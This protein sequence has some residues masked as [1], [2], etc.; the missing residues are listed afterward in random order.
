LRTANATLLAER[1]ALQAQLD[2]YKPQMV[3]DA[4]RLSAVLPEVPWC[5]MPVWHGAHDAMHRHLTVGTPASKLLS[6]LN[7]LMAGEAVKPRA[8]ELQ[9][10]HSLLLRGKDVY[11]PENLAA[12]LV[13]SSADVRC[14]HV[15]TAWA[16]CRSVTPMD[17]RNTLHL[18]LRRRTLA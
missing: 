9:R 18:W 15:M 1:Q 14:E 17:M 5:L 11:Q 8:N 13:A 10:L 4:G 7:Q 3:I 16:R 12:K 2:E 6:L